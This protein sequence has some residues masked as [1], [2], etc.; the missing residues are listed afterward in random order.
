MLRSEKLYVVA[1][2]AT[3]VNNGVTTCPV[4]FNTTC[5]NH[6]A[7]IFISSM[8]AKPWIGD[9]PK[10]D[11]VPLLI[12]LS[13][14][15]AK[16]WTGD[17]P[18]FDEAPLLIVLSA[19]EA[20]LWIG[21]VPKFGGVLLLI[22]LSIA[23]IKFAYWIDSNIDNVSAPNFSIIW[24]AKWNYVCALAEAFTWRY[25]LNIYRDTQ[26]ILVEMRRLVST[27]EFPCITS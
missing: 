5:S 18:K 14:T 7:T 20:K 16:P 26:C 27:R 22:A 2:S 6:S 1:L 23:K 17:D 8:E 12:T 13:T 9:V 3:R 10:F 25:I 24:F 21:D 11:A 19:I 4:A 15:E